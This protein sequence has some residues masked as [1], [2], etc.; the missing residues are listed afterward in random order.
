MKNN[1]KRKEE[2]EKCGEDGKRKEGG[3]GTKRKWAMETRGK[4]QIEQ[5]PSE[6]TEC[7]VV[8]RQWLEGIIH[9]CNRLRAPTQRSKLART[10]L[11]NAESE[12]RYFEQRIWPFAWAFVTFRATCQYQTISVGQESS[13]GT[14]RAITH[15]A[16]ILVSLSLSLSLSL[17]PSLSIFFLFFCV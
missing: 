12:L 6:T 17:P 2:K 13:R 5:K 10:G 7:F 8:A 3:G 1:E 9:R 14:A 15:V 4:Q 16:I 11:G